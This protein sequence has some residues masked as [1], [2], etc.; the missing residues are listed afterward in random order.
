M[1]EWIL[2]SACVAEWIKLLDVEQVGM[3][4]NPTSDGL[5]Q[6]YQIGNFCRD[7]SSLHTRSARYL[8]LQ[9][10][11]GLYR[12]LGLTAQNVIGLLIAKL[13]KMAF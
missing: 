6:N 7:F 13:Q 8:I 11:Y 9:T 3:S 5:I 12:L 10:D 1:A 2:F 4:L